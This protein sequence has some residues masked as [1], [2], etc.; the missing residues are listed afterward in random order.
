M[1]GRLKITDTHPKY[2]K[3]L[4][5]W[6]RCADAIDGTDAVKGDNAQRYLPPISVGQLK[7]EYDSYKLR[8][9]WY[10]AVARTLDGL[11]GL[12]FSAAPAMEIPSK[13]EPL[14][15]DF[16][17]QGTI[18]EEFCERVVEK[19]VGVGRCGVL[20]DHPPAVDGESQAD[21]EI[22]GYRPYGI[23]YE[24]DQIVNWRM[25]RVNNKH[26]LLRVVLREIYEMS[27]QKEET[28]YRE[29]RL[30][31]IKGK[32]IYSIT[33]WRRKMS[34][35]GKQAME[36]TITEE[37]GLVNPVVPLK[38]NAPISFIPFWFFGP[39]G[40]WSE[41]EKPPL[42]DLVDV[43]FSHYRTMADLEHARF[44]TALPTLVLCGFPE[45]VGD[46]PT[47]KIRLGS[48]SGI[49]TADS[50]SKAEWLT[51]GGQ[52]LAALEAAALQK[53]TMMARLG[54][55][56]LA[57]EKRAVETAESAMIRATGENSVLASIVNAIS[58]GLTQMMQFA[59]E[60]IGE[61]GETVSIE[62]NTDY[63]PV[64][65]TAQELVALTQALQ[66]GSLPRFDYFQA[67]KKGKVIGDE[68]S[69]EDFTNETETITYVP[70]TNMNQPPETADANAGKV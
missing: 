63:T 35:D 46:K 3:F 33:I 8:A 32:W 44:F 37:P 29:L 69:F 58:R 7:D 49:A 40:N 38:D 61:K 15:D 31:Q 19:V 48:Q 5:R 45:Y 18:L 42:L 53:E 50:S 21:A 25:G 16:D 27:D 62:L 43:N 51:Y 67:L 10:N 23:L 22:R 70:E 57:E 1:G 13:C 64:Q 28:Q 65:L 68:R 20:I 55:R 66:T 30:D 47:Q 6:Q 17:M 4:G 11:T 34:A 59:A 14:V 52:G 9:L 26:V 2:D 24:A 54:A 39:T 56:M 41:P 60:W 36:Y 12:V